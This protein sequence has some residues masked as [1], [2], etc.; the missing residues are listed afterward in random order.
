LY[1]AVKKEWENHNEYCKN[2]MKSYRNIC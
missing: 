2:Y 1:D